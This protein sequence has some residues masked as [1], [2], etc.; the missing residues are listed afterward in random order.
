VYACPENLSIGS[1]FVNGQTRIDNPL[2]KYSP[3]QLAEISSSFARHNFTGLENLFNKAASCARDP[4]IAYTIPGLTDEERAALEDEDKVTFWK[5]PKQLK[6]AIFT[7][8]LGAI[9]Q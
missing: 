5:Q 6:I 2:R 8:C 4:E 3:E 1:L 9:I 7:C